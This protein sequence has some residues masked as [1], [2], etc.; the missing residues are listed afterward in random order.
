[1]AI[2]AFLFSL[3]PVN[4]PRKPNT[5]SFLLSISMSVAGWR[6]LFF[7]EATFNPDA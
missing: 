4:S 2:K 6:I 5:L 3:P 1:M 7:N